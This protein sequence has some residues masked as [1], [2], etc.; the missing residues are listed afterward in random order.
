MG[1]KIQ[2][3]KMSSDKSNAEQLFLVGM[4]ASMFCWG[5]SWASAKVLGSYG[6]AISISLIRYVC[7]FISLLI[8]LLVTRKNLS[9]KKSGLKDLIIASIILALY[10]YLFFKG[11]E[12]GLAGAGGVLVTILNPIISYLI[13]LLLS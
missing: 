13:M 10:F 11:L 2:Q 1:A 5:L 8:L 6:E 9:I 4:I 12:E 3:E 7:T